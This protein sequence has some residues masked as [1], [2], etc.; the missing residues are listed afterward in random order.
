LLDASFKRIATCSLL[1]RLVVGRRGNL[2]T[3]QH[4]VAYFICNQG[5]LINSH[6]Y[7][8][9]RFAPKLVSNQSRKRTFIFYYV[10]AF[11]YQSTWLA[12]TL[13]HLAIM[14]LRL[15]FGQIDV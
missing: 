1:V 4:I 14:S 2:R 8:T 15:T 9:F 5:I 6:F 10:G 13:F 11:A 3:F 12:F 7:F